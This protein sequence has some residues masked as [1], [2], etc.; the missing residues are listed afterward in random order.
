MKRQRTYR[1]IVI[2]LPFFLLL[3]V[4]V[5][6]RLVDFGYDNRLFIEAEDDRFLVMNRDISQKYFTINQNATIGNQD[7]FYRRKPKNTLRFFV[8]GGSSALGFPY[9]HNGSFARMLKYKLQ[10]Q[11]PDKNIEIINL[12]LTAIN[13]YTLYDFSK[14]LINDQPDGI[15]IYAGHNEYYGA[16]GVASSSWLGSSPRWV[17]TLLVLRQLKLV[18]V[19][20]QLA[21][22]F[23]SANPTLVDK[24][25]TLLERMA[26]RQ[27]IP[28]QSESYKSG[29]K[30][31][32]Y[33]LGSMLRLFSK[34]GIP[35]FIGTLASNHRG[36]KPLQEEHVL[37]QYDANDEYRLAQKSFEQLAFKESKKHFFLAKEYDA[38][39]FRAPDEFNEI[40]EGYTVKM[41]GIFLVKT[42][43]RL[44]VNSA[45]EIIGNALMLEHV[46]PN[47]KGQKLLADA[48]YDA[49]VKNFAAFSNTESEKLNIDLSKDYPAT[50]FDSIYGELVVWK[51]KQQWPFNEQPE[52]PVYDQT[53]FEYEMAILFF[54]QKLN[55]GEAMQM[56]N[57]HY[58]RK[59]DYENA[60]RIV[61]QMCLELPHETVFLKQAASLCQ[62]LGEAEKA[63]YYLKQLAYDQ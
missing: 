32:Q 43:E 45:H 50:A 34:N 9:M 61:E 39:R 63:K 20:D 44:E 6:L 31:F 1:L 2:A 8:L 36:Q 40:I 22:K 17:R 59:R 25:R 46:H 29:V 4:E 37:S 26:A 60:L 38:L 53:N 13:S 11:F 47:L 42:K 55:W 28:Y 5:V 48:F 3:L 14:Q 7:V 33:N 21:A 18:Q 51:L 24:N 30:Q 41:D 54:F 52:K 35:V 16:L 62:R 19:L 15:L 10:F 58:I 49:L 57:N 12:S 23:H 27:E 56:L